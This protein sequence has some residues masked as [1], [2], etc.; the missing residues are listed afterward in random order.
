[1]ISLN[2]P[3]SAPEAIDALRERFLAA[4]PFQHLV[5][6]DAFPRELLRGVLTEFPQIRHNGKYFDDTAQRKHSCDDWDLFPPRTWEFISYLNTGSFVRFL[7]KVTGISELTSDPYLH[8][9]GI[10]E[11]FP[12]GFLKMHTDFNFHKI[13]KLDRRINILLFLNEGWEP[14]WGGEL[15][16]SNKA[17]TVQTRVE[18]LF[19]RMVVFNTNDHSFHGQPDPHSFPEGNSRK[20]IAMYYYSKG[21]PEHEITSHKIGTSY[22]ARFNGDFPMRARLKEKA[23][24]WLG[25]KFPR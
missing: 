12:G 23:R 11:T 5:L 1:M 15:V 2:E 25:L 17:M 16:L 6:D 13:L 4:A 10:H 21:R 22:R 9:G 7:A 19:N 8:G 3:F 14:S 20:S 18:P 24:L